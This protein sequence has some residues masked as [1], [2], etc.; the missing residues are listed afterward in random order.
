MGGT[1]PQ[2]DGSSFSGAPESGENH[3]RSENPA[4]AVAVA[5]HFAAEGAKV[6]I[7]FL[8]E[9]DDARITCEEIEKRGGE[10]IS[11]A[12][13]IGEPEV[14]Q[15]LIDKVLERWGR[16][17]VL[18]N[19]AGEQDVCEGLEEIEQAQWER[20]FRTN[21]FTMFQLTKA[22]LLHLGEGATTK[23][24]RLVYA[25]FQFLTMPRTFIPASASCSTISAQASA[26]SPQ[27]TQSTLLVRKT[28]KPI[29]RRCLSRDP[30]SQAA[31]TVTTMAG[32]CTQSRYSI[33]YPCCQ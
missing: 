30:T 32:H 20:T 19:N 29:S 4:R 23:G 26:Y 7:S 17:D 21:V 10:F 2:P 14:C 24:F 16:L 18:V 6:L 27:I 33:A 12:G 13:D 25:Y 3:E 15:V 8:N 31:P 28:Q 22:A 1:P 11:H 5:V 9:H